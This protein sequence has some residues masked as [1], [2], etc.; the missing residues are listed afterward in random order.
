M[1]FALIWTAAAFLCGSIPFGLIA[2][3][4]GRV[5]LRSIGSGNIGATNVWRALGWRWGLSVF[6]LDALK[7]FAPVFLLDGCLASGGSPDLTGARQLGLAMAAGFAAALGHTFSPL[8]G[9]RGGKGVAT[10]LGAAVALYQAW[11]LAPLL[12]FALVLWLTRMVSA[13]S[14]SGA[15]ALALLGFLVPVALP[16][17]P[18]AERIEGLRWFG[19][20]ACTLIF[21]THK[22]N[23]KRILAGTENRIGRKPTQGRKGKSGPDDKRA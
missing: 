16:S 12:V 22:P 2:A 11:I 8:A 5:D 10:G 4:I 1:P 20:G 6:L 17:A 18:L 13:G 14:L 15:L 9:G 23:L 7:G 3:R 21:F 19:L